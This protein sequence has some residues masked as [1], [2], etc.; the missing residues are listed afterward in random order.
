MKWGS[1]F[2]LPAW[3]KAWW[4][5][6]GGDAELYLRTLRDGEQIVGF[7]PLL[8]DGGTARFVGDADV[9]DYLDFVVAPGYESDLF[10]TL[11]DDLRATGIRSLDLGPVR[12]DSAVCTHLEAIAR[13]RG[14]GVF[15]RPEDVSLELDLPVT[16]HEY[17]AMLKTR[18]R[19]EIRRKIRRLSEAGNAEHRCAAGGPGL[20]DH[21]EAFLQLFSLSRDEKAGFMNP[22]M[23]YFFRSLSRAMSEIGLLRFGILELDGVPAAM[24]MGF[25]FDGWHYLYNSAYSPRFDHLSVG[26]LCKVLCLKESIERGS[27]KWSFLKGGE[28]YKYQLGGQ[29]MPLYSYRVD[30]S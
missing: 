5:S 7:A 4:D 27:E 24:T 16:W 1:V 28:T 8:V 22:R 12:P 30:I 23:E 13:R 9:C 6:F 20:Q 15:R 29:E 11:F 25:D 3:L 26:L 17:L 2:V 14:Y 10:E 18:Q 21:L 19:H